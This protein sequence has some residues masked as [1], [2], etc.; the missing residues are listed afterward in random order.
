LS[1][2]VAESWDGRLQADSARR[3]CVVTAPG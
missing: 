3:W 1:T 2:V